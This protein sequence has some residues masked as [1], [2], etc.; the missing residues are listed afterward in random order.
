VPQGK[1]GVGTGN[2]KAAP[3]HRKSET[4]SR[5]FKELVHIAAQQGAVIEL[6]VSTGDA[7]QQCLDRAVAMWRYAAQQVDA[8]VTPEDLPDDAE[9]ANLP[10]EEDPF[11]EVRANPNGPP[12]VV[13]HRWIEMEREARKDIE[14]LAAMMT[15]LG[16]AE[17]VVRVEEAK[18]ALLVAAVRE[19][20][21]EAG[22]D[23]DQVRALGAALR[24]RL[25]GAQKRM[26]AGKTTEEKL[27]VIETTAELEAGI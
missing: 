12:V 6:G 14:K 25:A 23:H 8:I 7:L 1:D 19:A 15:Q 3:G 18:A 13:R 16:I 10:V 26:P 27:D 21:M 5:V 11:F 2:G 9:V 24:N 17:R 4:R 22:L 20:A